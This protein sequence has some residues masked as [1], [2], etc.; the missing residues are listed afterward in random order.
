MGSFEDVPEAYRSPSHQQAWLDHRKIRAFLD[1]GCYREKDYL[2][3]GHYYGRRYPDLFLSY[4]QVYVLDIVRDTKDTIVSHYYHFKRERGVDWDF[5]SYYWRIGR[6]K[7]YQI[8]LYHE[9]WRGSS[10]RVYTSSFERLKQDFE[11][12]VANIGRFV[13]RTLVAEDIERIK[14]ETSITSMQKRHGQDAKK[15]TERFF[16]KGAVGDWKSHFDEQ[17]LDDI[18]KIERGELDLLGRSLYHLFFSVR[19]FLTRNLLRR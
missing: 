2:S 11:E 4:D 1:S 13:G 3:K 14:R 9:T 8:W 7:A 12:E 6:F 5:S 19:P 18:S 16:R 15:E 17:M 10:P